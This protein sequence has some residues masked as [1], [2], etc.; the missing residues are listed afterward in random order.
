MADQ[1]WIQVKIVGVDV[2]PI[3]QRLIEYCAAKAIEY[4]F[5]SLTLHLTTPRLRELKAEFKDELTFEEPNHEI[6]IQPETDWSVYSF[7]VFKAALANDLDRQS[8][9]D[10]HNDFHALFVLSAKNLSFSIRR[11]KFEDIKLFCVRYSYKIKELSS[12]DVIIPKLS[13]TNT[14]SQNVT[15]MMRAFISIYPAYAIHCRNVGDRNRFYW[16]Y[17]VE[18]E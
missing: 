9:Q 2:T 6:R 18:S 5:G 10:F 3:L 1:Q 14:R 11:E 15:E 13:P 12:L 16:N 4:V 17:C 8:S 7:A